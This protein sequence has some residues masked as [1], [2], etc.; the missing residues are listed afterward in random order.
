M[1][2]IRAR[3]IDRVLRK[4]GRL[5]GN[6]FFANNHHLVLT[7]LEKQYLAAILPLNKTRGIV[8]RLAKWDEAKH[9]RD[10]RGRFA[11]KNAEAVQ[12]SSTLDI[13][14]AKLDQQPASYTPPV[15]YD[16]PIA[17]E[18]VSREGSTHYSLPDEE[19]GS[20]KSQIEYGEA[21][22]E[23]YVGAVKNVLQKWIAVHTNPEAYA[24]DTVNTFSEAGTLD[25]LVTDITRW[26][27]IDEPRKRLGGRTF[28]TYAG[29]DGEGEVLSKYAE[30]IKYDFDFCEEANQIVGS[31]TKEDDLASYVEQKNDELRDEWENQPEDERPDKPPTIS[32]DDLDTRQA[33]NDEI[34]EYIRDV[35][36][37]DYENIAS[38]LGEDGI[39]Q[40]IQKAYPYYK[41]NTMDAIPE[42]EDKIREVHA[43]LR[44]I[45][46][47]QDNMELLQ[48][49]TWAAH[50][51]H[52]TTQFGNGTI[53][54][55]YGDQYGIDKEVL[56]K[57]QEEGLVAVFGQEAV[58]EF[59]GMPSSVHKSKLPAA[60]RAAMRA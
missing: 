46:N 53:I 37:V 52:A 45:E 2:L 24:A 20:L 35:A 25:E 54:E 43:H 26:G 56:N 28:K 10:K 55:A 14:P 38:I 19:Y 33:T 22:V 7:P 29:F 5:L 8:S 1:A 17:D 4:G 3:E 27:S 30:A 59:L 60:V 23:D 39:A 18:L 48:A 6:V 49:I 44:A 58:D 15:D 47:A 32:A 42:L 21:T 31:Y 36:G 12:D 57:I 50:Q 13:S 40:I 16:D 11:P 51:E 41:G 34:V 9:A